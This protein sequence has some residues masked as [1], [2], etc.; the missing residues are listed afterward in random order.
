LQLPCFPCASFL[1]FGFNSLF[2]AHASGRPHFWLERLIAGIIPDTEN[3][4]RDVCRDGGRNH[5]TSLFADWISRSGISP[6]GNRQG[7]CPRKGIARSF[8]RVSSC[9]SRNAAT[10]TVTASCGTSRRKV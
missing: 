5:S 7:R 4:L 10:P 3:Q 1:L 2:A 9:S 6:S 8:P